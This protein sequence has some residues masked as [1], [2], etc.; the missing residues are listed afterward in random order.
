[1]ADGDLTNP[2]HAAAA[3]LVG[4]N[5]GGV[6]CNSRY[7][8]RR[9]AGPQGADNARYGHVQAGREKVEAEAID[10]QA[11]VRSRVNGAA[12]I[13]ESNRRSG[14]ARIVGQVSQRI[15]GAIAECSLKLIRVGER[16]SA[17]C[18]VGDTQD[19]IGADIS[20][21][22]T[23]GMKNLVN[24]A[25]CPQDRRNGHAEVRC[26]RGKPHAEVSRTASRGCIGC[27][28]LGAGVVRKTVVVVSAIRVG[29]VT[30]RGRTCC[31]VNRVFRHQHRGTGGA[32][33]DYGAEFSQT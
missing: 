31:D 22:R 19:N 28:A 15:P 9:H 14:A 13:V 16:Q 24:S 12:L 25:G 17:I 20:R 2:D 18:G 5:A 29:S 26:R 6:G 30:G 4:G 21:S 32:Q 11:H 7:R 3:V 33:Q 1:M 27:R 8:Y 23:V 10:F